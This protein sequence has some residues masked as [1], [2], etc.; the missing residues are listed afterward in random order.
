MPVRKRCHHH[1]DHDLHR[2]LRGHRVEIQRHPGLDPIQV[3]RGLLQFQADHDVDRREKAQAQDRHQRH[4]RQRRR[5]PAVRRPG[6][7][8]I[9]KLNREE[10]ARRAADD[11]HGRHQ[12]QRFRRQPADDLAPHRHID[13]PQDRPEHEAHEQVDAGPQQTRRDVHEIQ[14]PEIADFD[15]RD[16]HAERG[17]RIQG[18]IPADQAFRRCNSCCSHSMTSSASVSRLPEIL[19]PSVLAVLRLNTVSNLDGRITGRSV[20]LTPLRMRPA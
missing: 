1:K 20:G 6:H 17:K 16:H 11:R 19:I 18:V 8:G 13:P 5:Y 14:K 2:A 9:A 3:R 4:Q 7:R 10:P 12:E 15:R